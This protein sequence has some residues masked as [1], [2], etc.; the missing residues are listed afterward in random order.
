MRVEGVMCGVMRETVILFQRFQTR[1]RS[2]SRRRGRASD[3]EL[4]RLCS[5]QQRTRISISTGEGVCVMLQTISQ[6]IPDT[7]TEYIRIWEPLLHYFQQNRPTTSSKNNL[8]N[9]VIFSWME[10][11]VHPMT[12][13]KKKGS[14]ISTSSHCTKCSRNTPHSRL[15]CLNR[16]QM[17]W[18]FVHMF[19]FPRER[20][21]ITI[22]IKQ[23]LIPQLHS[24]SIIM[25]F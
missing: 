12:V 8:S 22:V 18:N 17:P 13:G 19:V 16:Y 20:I 2:L 9:L 7:N 11:L 10:M 14:P 5:G 15:K 25:L 24:L 23:L 21:P 6:Y 1:D 3:S 4:D